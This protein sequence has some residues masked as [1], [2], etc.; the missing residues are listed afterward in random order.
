MKVVV[1]H[2]QPSVRQEVRRI[3]ESDGHEV[4][5]VPDANSVED[6]CSRWAP[7]V[8]LLHGEFSRQVGTSLVGRIKAHQDAFFTAIVVMDHEVEYACALRELEAGAH[9]FLSEPFN[10]AE[11]VARVQSAARTKSLQEELFLQSKRLETLIYQD[12]LTG[13]YNRRFLLNQLAALIS[14]ARRHDRGLA[15]VMIDVDRFKLLNDTYGHGVGDKVLVKVARALG[16]R[17]RAEDYL[18]RLGGEE[19]LALVPDTDDEGAGRVAESLRET[20]ASVSVEAAGEPVGVS[21]SAGWAVWRGETPDELL[22][23]ADSA[24]YDAKQAGR[25]TVRGA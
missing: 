23:R 21:V 5:E 14:S 7:D 25:D 18:G 22:K 15:V 24:M 6:E 2:V 19:F 20:A 4:L 16:E 11:L 17:L 13:L 8:T 1:A 10:P 3:L 12:A 9:D